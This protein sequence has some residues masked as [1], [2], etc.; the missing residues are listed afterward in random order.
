MFIGRYVP[1]AILLSLGGSMIGRKRNTVSGLK[2]DSIIFSLVLIGC[3]LIIVVL[4]FFPFLTLGPILSY[5]Q[6]KVNEFG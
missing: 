6:G 4:A 1:I 2:T 5:F 3:I